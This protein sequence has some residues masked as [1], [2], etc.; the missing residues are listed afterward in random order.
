MNKKE[1]IKMLLETGI[2]KQNIAETFDMSISKIDEIISS[3][4]TGIDA[5]P[6]RRRVRVI[7]YGEEKFNEAK[8]L[9]AQGWS[10]RRIAKYQGY[11]ESFIYR[12]LRNK[13]YADLEEMRERDRICSAARKAAHEP[14]HKPEHDI[15]QTAETVRSEPALEK[16]EPVSEKAE[17]GTAEETLAKH[18]DTSDDRMY[19]EIR[20]IAGSL[21]RIADAL[22]LKKKSPKKKRGLFRR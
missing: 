19:M 13:T 21:A 4:P 3:E 22:E 5:A 10:R 1:Q 11:S 14:E 17:Q 9:H 7:K 15:A 18:N 20:S 6:A 12:V 16:V 8:K 2:P